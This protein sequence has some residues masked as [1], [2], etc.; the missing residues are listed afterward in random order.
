MI[1]QYRLT[2]ITIIAKFLPRQLFLIASITVALHI[3]S[4]SISILG[5]RWY[6]Q[7][8][9]LA[10][11]LAQIFSLRSAKSFENRLAS[12]SHPAMMQGGSSLLLNSPLKSDSKIFENIFVVN[13]EWKRI[14]L[15]C[16]NSI[17]LRWPLNRSIILHVCIFATYFLILPN[18]IQ[19]SLIRNEILISKKMIISESMAS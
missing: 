19:M 18:N 12:S 13:I 11:S 4:I 2:I 15:Y 8:L 17:V 9:K 14:V 7:Q 1:S 10:I 3:L 6:W 5:Q 16:D